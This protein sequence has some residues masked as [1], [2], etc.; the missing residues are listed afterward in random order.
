[1]EYRARLVGSGAPVRLL[2]D[3][4]GALRVEPADSA[5]DGLWLSE[6]WVDI[7]VNGYMGHDLNIPDPDPATV[8]KL[9]R[10]LW[11]E[12]VTSFCPTVIT[13]SGERIGRAVQTVAAACEADPLTARSVV[14]IHVEGPY[15]SAVDGPRGAHPIEH[16][17]PPSLAE[18]ATWQEAAGGRI[19]LITLAPEHEGALPFI[20]AVASQGVVVSLGHTAADGDTIRQAVDAGARLSTHLGNGAHAQIQRHPNYIWEQ[21]AED[22]LYASLIFDGHH[23]P[24]AVMKSMFRCKGPDRSILVSDAVAVGGLPPGVYQAG[25]GGMVELLPSGRLNLQGTPYLAGSA[26]P[27][28]VGIGNAVRAAGADLKTAV[29]M[30]SANP[31]QLMGYHRT[32]DWVLFRFDGND[33]VPTVQATFVGSRMVYHADQGVLA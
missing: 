12:G 29:R 8:H 22:R 16:V 25:V 7:Q 14:G 6:G 27:I 18:F 26:S 13:Q 24:P 33:S 17:R 3:V 23:L 1:M 5:D 32:D 19:R 2:V 20:A 11:A 4:D 9:V 10:A 15:I 30:A 31:A 28:R 21:L